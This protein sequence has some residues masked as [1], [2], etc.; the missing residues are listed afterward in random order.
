MIDEKKE[1]L[2]MRAGMNYGV[3]NQE[4]YY[5]PMGVELNDI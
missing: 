3:G 1:D 2:N 4:L 5:K